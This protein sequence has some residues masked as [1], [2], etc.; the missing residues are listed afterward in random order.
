MGDKSKI[1]KDVIAERSRQDEKWGEQDHSAYVWASIIGEE[2]GE[3]CK[4]VNEFGFNPTPET[5][6]DIYTEAIRTM[7]SC[8]AMLEC[9]ERSRM[10]VGMDFCGSE[11][12]DQTHIAYMVPV[13][14]LAKTMKYLV[15]RCIPLASINDSL[16][17]KCQKIKGKKTHRHKSLK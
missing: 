9:V 10:N 4:A 3:M 1:I 6:Q 12:T 2:Y 15:V 17:E 14:E 13:H 7:A 5:E 8:M 16:I 11:K